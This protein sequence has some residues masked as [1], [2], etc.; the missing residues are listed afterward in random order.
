MPSS[1]RKPVL[2]KPAFSLGRDSGE[3]RGVGLESGSTGRNAVE[4]GGPDRLRRAGP[5]SQSQGWTTVSG[6]LEVT[7]S[8]HRTLRLVTAGSG[9][10][11]RPAGQREVSQRP[12]TDQ[13]AVVGRSVSGQSTVTGSVSEHRTASRRLLRLQTV[14]PRRT[15]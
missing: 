15:A 5:V 11:E 9:Q 3:G 7:G 14:A 2:L 4:K 8:G 13:S 1:Y 12:V 6:R 10:Q